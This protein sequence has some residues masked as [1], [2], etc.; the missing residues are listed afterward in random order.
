VGPT[1][2]TGVAAQYD[3]SGNLMPIGQ[4]VEAGWRNTGRRAP[5]GKLIWEYVGHTTTPATAGTQGVLGRA[6]NIDEVISLRGTVVN[7]NGTRVPI[8]YYQASSGDN[9]TG[10]VAPDGTINRAWGIGSGG[11]AS[12]WANRPVNYVLEAT[13]T[14]A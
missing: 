8:N 2:L 10:T 6:P 13:R 14:D 7:S 12:V 4:N 11:A 1:G 3:N 5:N 9:V